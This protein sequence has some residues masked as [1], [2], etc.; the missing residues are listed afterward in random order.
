MSVSFTNYNNT[1]ET[2]EN[3]KTHMLDYQTPAIKLYAYPNTKIGN[4][5]TS[6]ANNQPNKYVKLTHYKDSYKAY[7]N[8]NC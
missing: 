8:Y 5:S 1:V 2:I 4:C 7:Q 3:V 6:F